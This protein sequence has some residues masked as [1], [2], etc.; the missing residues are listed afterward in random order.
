[1]TLLLI[2]LS[3]FAFRYHHSL[4]LMLPGLEHGLRRV[5]ACV[6]HCPHRAITAEVRIYNAVKSDPTHMHGKSLE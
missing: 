2:L 1:M 6:N 5:F 3:W 4:V